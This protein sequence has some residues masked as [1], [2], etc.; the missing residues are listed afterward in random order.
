MTVSSLKPPSS[1]LLKL[2][3]PWTR[4]LIQLKR[5][6]K[7]LSTTVGNPKDIIILRCIL[8]TLAIRLTDRVNQCVSGSCWVTHGISER[9][10]MAAK[11]S[12]KELSTISD[13]NE[14][15][16]GE[17]K[18]YYRIPGFDKDIVCTHIHTSKQVSIAKAHN[19]VF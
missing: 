15:G 8:Q 7:V 13:K 17:S 18:V 1:D 2:I 9:N 5:L 4:H 14:T 10:K 11:E 12:V 6:K 16:C 3:P 19:S